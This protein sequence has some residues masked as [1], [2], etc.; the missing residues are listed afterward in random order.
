MGIYQLYKRENQLQSTA[1]NPDPLL[2]SPPR[3]PPTLHKDTLSTPQ[4]GDA[5]LSTMQGGR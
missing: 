3:T 1:M 2:T 4:L 5:P